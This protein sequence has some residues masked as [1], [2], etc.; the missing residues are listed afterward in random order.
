MGMY[1]SISN[2]VGDRVG[3]ELKVGD[4]H[5]NDSTT[6]STAPKYV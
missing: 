5:D 4:N 1:S 6:Q 2:E 3:K